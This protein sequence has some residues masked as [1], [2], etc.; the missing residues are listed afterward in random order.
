MW[1]I[2]TPLVP[3]EELQILA[4]ENGQRTMTRLWLRL[5]FAVVLFLGPLFLLKVVSIRWLSAGLGMTAVSFSLAPIFIGLDMHL[6]YYLP[7]IRLTDEGLWVKNAKSINHKF[8]SYQDLVQIE[9][10]TT[11]EKKMKYQV[12]LIFIRGS[13]WFTNKRPGAGVPFL[14]HLTNEVNKKCNC[15]VSPVFDVE[16][17]SEKLV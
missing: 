15:S 1:S 7:G 6:F 16:L 13:S 5:I 12:R 14:T 3:G 2:T 8:Y 10:L 17:A 4:Y 11:N 9:Q